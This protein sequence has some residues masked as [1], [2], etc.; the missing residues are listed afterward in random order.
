VTKAKIAEQQ[1]AKKANDTKKVQEMEQWGKGHQEL[2]HQQLAGEAP[3]TNILEMMTPGFAEIA[4][5]AQV[6][7]IVPDVLYANAGVQTVDVTEQMLDWLKA[8]ET[9]RKIVLEVRSHPGP[10]HAH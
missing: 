3:L 6:G 8:D 5:K 1:A 4:Q 2:A 10:V 7:L 9:T